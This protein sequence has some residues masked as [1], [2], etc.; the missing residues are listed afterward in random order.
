MNIRERA[1]RLTAWLEGA[2]L[3]LWRE[4]GF[5]AG[6]GFA[7]TI[8]QDGRATTDD[9]RARVNPR[10]VY[11]FAEAGRRGWPGDWRTAVLGGLERF[12]RVYRRPDG[13]YGHLATCEGSLIDD[14]FDLYNQAFALLA[15]AAI[16]EAMPE[17]KPE[18]AA[19]ALSLLEALRARFAHPKGGFHESEPPA[20]PLRSN[21]HMHLFEA[22]QAWETVAGVEAGPW[23]DLADEIA[24]LCL[25][26]FIDPA[27]GFLREFFDLGWQPAEGEAGSVVEPGHQFEWAWLLARWARR[28]GGRTE[29]VR[30]AARLFAVGETHGVDGHRG[31]AVMT[32]SDALVV[33]DPIARLWVQTEWLKSAVLLAVLAKGEE[34]ERYLASAERAGDALAAFIATSQPGLWHDKQRADGTFVD[35]PAPASSFYHIVCAIGELDDRLQEL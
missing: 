16:A 30:R 8:A 22:A 23:R 2:A 28:R 35:E 7:E 19:R 12:D 13:F 11:C 21:P 4:R 10:Q 1:E 32:L 17:R 3:P 15:F 29:A 5:S 34:R 18:M 6:M 25:A 24:E 14:R 20:P 26:R 9:V 31:V 27:G 33:V